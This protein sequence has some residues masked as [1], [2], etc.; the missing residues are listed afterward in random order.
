MAAPLRTAMAR[1]A[2]A[3]PDAQPAADAGQAVLA[4]EPLVE[5]VLQRRYK[6]FLADVELADGELVTAH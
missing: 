6:R 4:L 2:A 1:A 3:P 5:G